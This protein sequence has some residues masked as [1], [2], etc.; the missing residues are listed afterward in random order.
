MEAVKQEK[1]SKHLSSGTNTG[2]SQSETPIS[3]HSL[4]EEHPRSHA[5]RTANEVVAS[6]SK[7]MKV[8]VGL[9]FVVIGVSI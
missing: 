5:E 9:E 2:G 7:S 8:N 6:N 1:E 3:E 4:G